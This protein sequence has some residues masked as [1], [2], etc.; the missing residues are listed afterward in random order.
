M[1]FS[2]CFLAIKIQEWP[3]GIWLLSLQCLFGW[4][5]SPVPHFTLHSCWILLFILVEFPGAVASGVPQLPRIPGSH[6]FKESWSNQMVDAEEGSWI[7]DLALNASAGLE[8][9]CICLP[10][11]SWWPILF[12]L[13]EG[14]V[15]TSEQSG[16]RESWFPLN[17]AWGLKTLGK[18]R[19]VLQENFLDSCWTNKARV[20]S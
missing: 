11:A 16:G 15:D 7:L 10:A 2:C 18:G 3:H 17:P 14:Q 6:L 19:Y 4:Q 13:P 1:S 12:P 5:W 9:V 20:C 8:F